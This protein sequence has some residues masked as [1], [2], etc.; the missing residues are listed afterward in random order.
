[1]YALMR[2]NRRPTALRY[3]V[4]TLQRDVPMDLGIRR[5]PLPSHHILCAGT[6]SPVFARLAAETAL[7]ACPEDLRKDFRLFIH[8]DGVAAPERPNLLAWLREIPRV[9]VTYGLFGILSRDRIPGKW[10]QVMINDVV[11]E[12]R[13]EP[14]LAF[15]DADLYLADESWWRQLSAHL[16]DELYAL[17]VGVRPQST[18]TIDGRSFVAMRT[19]LFTVN[20]RLHIDLNQQRY[21]KDERALR[22]LR[23]EFPNAILDVNAMDSQ[24]GA[25]LRAQ[26]HGFSIRNV[27]DD[28]PCCH[29]GGFSHLKAG[30][31]KDYENPARLPS[32]RGLLGQARFLPRVIDYFDGRGWSRFVEPSFRRDVAAMLKYIESIEVLRD[33]MASQPVT[34]REAIFE[35]VV[36]QIG[37]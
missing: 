12:F 2:R 28:V 10:H 6:Y 1:M 25:S 30:K 20:T 16:S 18:L 17:T 3:L 26:A 15:I 9:E 27:A 14:H 8:V 22:L 7:Q 29:I 33:I 4:R 31:F 11:R 5:G 24:I 21:S 37:T 32:I 35:Q 36:G 13:S 34:P 19:N 23:R